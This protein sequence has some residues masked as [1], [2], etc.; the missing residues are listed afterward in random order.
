MM[1]ATLLVPDFYLQAAL[2]HAP[3]LREKPVALID[4]QAAKAV[5]I[6]LNERAEEAGVRSGMAPSQGLAR[7]MQL[8]VRTRDR[9]QERLLAE[10]V[11]ESAFTLA[12][13]VEATASGVWTIQFSDTRSMAENVARV[14]DT[15]SAIEITARAGIAPTP[16][17]S[18]LAAHAAT[19]VLKIDD[20]KDFLASL[21]LEALANV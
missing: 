19:P 21:P 6:Q 16:D 7:C 18:L 12:P 5:I 14:I 15:L 8:V 2:R 11:L 4:D 10:I 13:D 20:A 3:E 9:L 17:A 1:F